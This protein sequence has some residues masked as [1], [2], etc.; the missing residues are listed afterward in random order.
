MRGAR[1]K[2]AFSIFQ[3]G[4]WAIGKVSNGYRVVSPSSYYK[5][6]IEDYPPYIQHAINSIL[7]NC[8]RWMCKGSTNFPTSPA[9]VVIQFTIPQRIQS[10][11]IGG[12]GIQGGLPSQAL[13]RPNN[14]QKLPLPFFR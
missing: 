4:R 14:C 3:N 8:R 1:K 13:S 11:A 10:A 12:S 2:A 6:D 5:V 7:G 9:H